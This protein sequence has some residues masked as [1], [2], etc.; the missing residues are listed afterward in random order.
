MPPTCAH[1]LCTLHTTRCATCAH[2]LCT[3]PA[4]PVRT[5]RATCA[6]PRAG[7]DRSV[8]GCH[9]LNESR[10]WMSLS[11]RIS[12][13]ISLPITSPSPPYPPSQPL[14]TTTTERSTSCVTTFHWGR[15]RHWHR[16]RYRALRLLNVPQTCNSNNTRR[17]TPRYRF[18]DIAARRARDTAPTTRLTLNTCPELQRQDRRTDRRAPPTPFAKTTRTTQK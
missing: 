9:S 2:T 1:P 10:S 4:Q 12:L 7:L 3:H 8:N 5:S 16:M 15:F 6:P 18:G 14:Q 13:R 11:L 17:N